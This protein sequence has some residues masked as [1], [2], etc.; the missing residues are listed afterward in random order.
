MATLL[1]V[2]EQFIEKIHP[3]ICDEFKMEDDDS[4]DLEESLELESNK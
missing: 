4:D 1:S 3:N 2:F